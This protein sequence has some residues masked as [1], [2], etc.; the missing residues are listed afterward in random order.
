LLLLY[1]IDAGQRLAERLSGLIRT[2]A[3]RAAQWAELVFPLH[4]HQQFAAPGSA[5]F[6]LLRYGLAW[7][8]LLDRLGFELSQWRR[9]CPLGSAAVAGSSIPIDRT[10]QARELGF[11]EPSPNAL[12]ST[13]ARDEC[14]EFVGLAA[15]V[16]LHDQSLATDLIVFAQTPLAWLKVPDGFATGSSMMPNKRNPDA[17]ELLR[18]EAASV[19]AAQFE[20]LTLLKGLPSGYNR[21]LQCVKPPLRRAAE[22]ILQLTGLVDAFLQAADFDRKRLTAAA[23]LGHIGATLEMERHVRAGR[24]LRQAHHAVADQLRSVPDPATPAID[25]P[26]E[27]YATCGSA[28]PAE[29]RRAAAALVA[30]LPA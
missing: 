8:R 26:L 16:A 9:W 17:L 12:Y 30:D 22:T 7:R 21:D 14:L 10:I 18:G 20:L 3:E 24:P 15:Q 25:R 1:V 19:V 23:R 11:E 6:W 27:L 13:S 4:T 5:G 2:T 28:H 29:V